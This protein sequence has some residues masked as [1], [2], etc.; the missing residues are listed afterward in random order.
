[1]Y[2][3]RPQLSYLHML[4]LFDHSQSIFCYGADQLGR[5]KSVGVCPPASSYAPFRNGQAVPKIR[6][7]TFVPCTCNDL[8]SSS[9][10][11]L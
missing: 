1:M 3:Q 9:E 11:N 5:V 2:T 7:S 6:A 8:S 10:A 4:G